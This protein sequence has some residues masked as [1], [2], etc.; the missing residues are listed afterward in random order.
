[1]RTR[2]L[3]EWILDEIGMSENGY[4]NTHEIKDKIDARSKQGTTMNSLSN[5]LAK[6]SA[7]EIVGVVRTRS[8]LNSGY[9][10]KVWGATGKLDGPYTR[11]LLKS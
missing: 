7:F 11:H 9:E 4:L 2:R 6:S 3:A 10:I 1:M 5:V 8:L